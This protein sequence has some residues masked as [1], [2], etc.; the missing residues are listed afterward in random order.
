MTD[1]ELSF[2]DIK[3]GAEKALENLERVVVVLEE[4]ATYL[5]EV[6]KVLKVL[7]ATL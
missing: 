2:D 5:P 7:Q 1:A 4:A 6:L 3:D